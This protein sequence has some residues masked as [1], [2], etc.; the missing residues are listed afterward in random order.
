MIGDVDTW[1]TTTSQRA[2]AGLSIRR[3]EAVERLELATLE[4]GLARVIAYSPG[5]KRSRAAWGDVREALGHQ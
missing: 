3:H 2:R 5:D 1:T 4:S